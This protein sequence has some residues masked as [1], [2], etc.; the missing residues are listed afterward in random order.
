[1]SSANMYSS[2]VDNLVNHADWFFPGGKY[3]LY[4]AV[5]G[6]RLC[7]RGALTRAG[8]CRNSYEMRNQVV[9]CS[10]FLSFLGVGIR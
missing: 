8:G 7:E 9:F 2:I 6:S 10:S 4:C 3:K 1:M 5:T